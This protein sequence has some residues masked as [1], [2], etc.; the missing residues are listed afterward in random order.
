[1]VALVARALRGRPA[2]A[3]ILPFRTRH[4]TAALTVLR[5]RHG[6]ASLLTSRLSHAVSVV[7]SLRSLRLRV[8]P[9]ASMLGDAC[10][11]RT[12]GTGRGGAQRLDTPGR[13]LMADGA[14]DP[15]RVDGVVHDAVVRETVVRDV[16]RLIEHGHVPLYRHD[17]APDARRDEVALLDE[18]ER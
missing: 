14:L 16:A 12:H 15:T 10:A 6:A 13:D 7:E 3:T 17:E 4:R 2:A 5:S 1:S 9:S 18:R 8:P 11:L